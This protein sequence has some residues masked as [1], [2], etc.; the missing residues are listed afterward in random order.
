MKAQYQNVSF[1]YYDDVQGLSNP[2]IIYKTADKF[3]FWSGTG[4]TKL[5][6]T[7]DNT[8]LSVEVADN[9]LNASVA[10]ISTLTATTIT[11]DISPNLTAGTGITLS[12]ASGVT[13]INSTGLATS[14]QYYFRVGSSSSGN[15]TPPSSATGTIL[16]FNSI[17]YD[18]P[19]T[20]G[21]RN[22]DIAT[23]RYTIPVDGTYKFSYHLYFQD[24][25]NVIQVM[26]FVDDVQEGGLFAGDSSGLVES[27]S[28]LI[29]CTAG[30]I[31]DVRTLYVG[32]SP[33]TLINM[34]VSWF[35]GFLLQ[36]ENNTITSSTALTTNSLT[37][38][39]TNVST[40]N[41]SNLTIDTNLNG[42][43][44]IRTVAIAKILGNG[45]NSTVVG[46]SVTRTAVGR[47]TC[48]ISPARPDDQYVVQCT[49]METSGALDDVVIHVQDG[50]MATTGFNYFIHEQ[51]NGASPGTYRDRNHFISVF[52][53][54]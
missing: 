14:Q 44:F 4:T 47:Y 33:T 18:V 37:T 1:M 8:N 15:Y 26:Y 39:T 43:A 28:I 9:K 49:T 30:Q 40:S 2:G 19:S 11:G 54:D 52:D 34:G 21:N 45:G 48:T 23:S 32:S 16:P 22:F 3:Q 5:V 36:P 38:T 41:V 25:N 51:D 10:N 27:A 42:Y 50:T 46:C 20:A 6:F 24:F 7:T 12:T 17:V 29:E 35:E 53:T 13:T 31:V